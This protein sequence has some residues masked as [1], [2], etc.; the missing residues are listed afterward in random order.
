MCNSALAD[1]IS[2]KIGED[3]ITHLEQLAQLKPLA[4]DER[5]QLDV[6]KVKNENKTKL[7]AYLE[8]KTGIKVN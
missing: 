3:W 1:V 8:E 6:M 4:N 7:A 2:D 5:Y